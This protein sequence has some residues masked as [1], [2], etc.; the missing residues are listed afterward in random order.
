[1]SAQLTGPG[2]AACYLDAQRSFAT[3]LR[4]LTPDQLML[5][6]PA[7]PDWSVRDVASHVAGIPE[8]AFAGRMEGS[9]TDPW[10]AAQIERWRDTPLDELLAQWDDRAEQFASLV[11]QFDEPRAVVD[12]HS[13]EHDVRGAIGQPGNRDGTVTQ[14]SAAV[15]VG[16]LDTERAVAVETIGGQRITGTGGDAITLR[17]V[18]PFEVV[19]SRLGRRSRAQVAAYDWSEDPGDVLDAWFMFGPRT[20]ELIE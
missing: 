10:T 13:H 6:V 7:C 4:S 16:A 17:G 20:D 19:R 3:L 14:T 9:G 1:M 11:E 18:T 12:C 15:L 2:I 8:D 5:R